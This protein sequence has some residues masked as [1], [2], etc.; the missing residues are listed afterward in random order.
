LSPSFFPSWRRK[1]TNLWEKWLI[2]IESDFTQRES[3]W[4]WRAHLLEEINTIYGRTVCA[5]DWVRFS[6]RK[7]RIDCSPMEMLIVACFL[8]PVA[9]NR[10]TDRQTDRQRVVAV[11]GSSVPL[12]KW[13]PRGDLH[14]VHMHIQ[15]PAAGTR[16][17]WQ[18]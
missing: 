8:F 1:Q 16:R 13:D 12:W 6:E 14:A 5:D 2:M 18:C 17:N 10:Q 9:Q 3:C 15:Q 7:L 11:N 4:S